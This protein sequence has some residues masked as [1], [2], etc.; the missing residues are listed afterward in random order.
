MRKLALGLCTSF[1]LLCSAWGQTFPSGIPNLAVRYEAD[2]ITFVS[3]VC[4]TPSNGSTLTTWA[5]ES[6]NANTA[7][8]GGGTCTFNTNQVNSNPA[9]TLASCWLTLGSSI[10]FYASGQTTFVVTKLSSTAGG[11]I[12]SGAGSASVTFS[13]NAS[14]L[15]IL[16]YTT[17]V[18]LGSGT[19]VSDLN[20]H[21][22]GFNFA[23][24]CDTTGTSYRVDETNDGSGNACGNP[25]TQT[26]I[27]RNAGNS[28]EYFP[29]QL[30]ALIS[31]TRMLT[32]SERCQ[33]EVYLAT[34]YTV[35]TGGSCPNSVAY[36]PQMR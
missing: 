5:D 18:G 34:K 32:T 14:H 3:S 25:T 12:W 13:A 19:F 20:W 29:G 6:G 23:V 4:G 30:A 2:C 10:A 17:N 15:N 22:R 36:F 31:Y 9:V 16:S 26:T 27:G 24:N 11:A 28:S 33:V 35:G 8:V 1:C 21:Q 7:T